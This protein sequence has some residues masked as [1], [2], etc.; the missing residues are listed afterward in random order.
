VEKELE[1]LFKAQREQALK[2]RISFAS[3]LHYRPH[4]SPV[5]PLYHLHPAPLNPAPPPQAIDPNLDSLVRGVKEQIQELQFKHEV[6][7]KEVTALEVMVSG[8]WSLTCTWHVTITLLSRTLL[9]KCMLW[10]C[11]HLLCFL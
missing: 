3:A 9:C 10:S 4:S 7:K 8:H 11:L 2:V 1:P 5:I 6:K